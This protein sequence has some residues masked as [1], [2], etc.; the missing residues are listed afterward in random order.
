MTPTPTLR[1]NGF[2]IVPTSPQ[3]VTSFYG[4]W[5][6]LPGVPGLI[7]G[8]QKFGVIDPKTGVEVGT[9]DALVARGNGL[10]Y[11]QLLVTSTD[12]ANAAADGPTPPVGSVISDLRLGP[13]GLCYSAL[14]RP[15]G[16]VVSFAITT[17]FGNIPVPMPFDY[18]K[19]IADHTVDNRPMRLGNGYSI[20]PADPD[21]ET[22]TGTTGILPGFMTVQGNQSFNV[23]DSAGHPV[24]TF[25][26]I[27]TTTSDLFFYTQAVMVTANDG[28]NVGSGPGQVPPVGSVYN[29]IYLGTDDHFLLYSSLPTTGERS[30]VSVIRVNKDK[31]TASAITLIDASHPPVSTALVG[32]GGIAFVP[33]SALTP[34]G[35]N[36]LPPR[37]VQ[38]QGYQRFD[39]YDSAGMKIGT[40]DADVFTQWDA[41]GVSSRALL[42]TRVTAGNGVP[43]AGSIVNVVSH[44]GFGSAHS[45]VVGMSENLTSFE[46]RTPLGPLPPAAVRSRAGRTPVSFYTP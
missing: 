2:D 6:Y 25:D 1:L 39:V 41:F 24:G 22:I 3:E 19:G 43:P 15:S 28:T 9:F 29:V 26:A 11:T 36:G 45:T 46:L 30:D 20:A 40:V 17:P 27:F 18:A 42:I 21:G 23:Y 37:E 44:G 10:G 16:N 13:I 31:V 35:V 34:S 8:R 12:S 5:A 7:Q 14:A 33:V 32:P 38:I 4:R